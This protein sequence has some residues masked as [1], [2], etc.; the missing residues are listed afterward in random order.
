MVFSRYEAFYEAF[1]VLNYKDNGLKP[2]Q[3]LEIDNGYTT[4]YQSQNHQ[5]RSI[6]TYLRH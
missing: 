4:N 1:I 3:T 5:E 2:H 6:E